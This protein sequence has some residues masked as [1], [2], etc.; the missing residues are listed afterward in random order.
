MRPSEFLA[1]QWSNYSTAHRN[2]TNLVI[3]LI[4]VPLF[5]YATVLLLYSLFFLSFWALLGAIV[6]LAVSLAL[7]G[8]GHRLEQTQPAPFKNRADFVWRLITE[9]WITFPRF[10]ISGNWSRNLRDAK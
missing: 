1:W 2:K 7:Q 5:M 8:R 3:H 6:C 10:V 4:A 9:N